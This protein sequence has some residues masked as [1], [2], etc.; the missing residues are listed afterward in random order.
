METLLFNYLL[1]LTE[2]IVENTTIKLNL[3]LRYYQYNDTYLIKLHIPLPENYPETGLSSNYMV[4]Q[5]GIFESEISVIGS[6]SSWI[7]DFNKLQRILQ[8]PARYGIVLHGF[9]IIPKRD[10]I[11]LTIDEQTFLKG[12]GKQALCAG[13]DHIIMILKMEPTQTILLLEASGGKIISEA[14]E[15]SVRDYMQWEYDDL[16]DTYKKQY[17]DDYIS[18]RPS[19]LDKDFMA[20]TLVTTNNNKRLIA[21]YKSTFGFVS[22]DRVIDGKHMGVFVDTFLDHC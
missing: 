13:I 21:Y 5:V 22:L 6:A 17:Y 18:Y 14:D 8:R 9:Y 16:L 1:P 3:V 4:N 11:S 15:E 2:A 12:L 19:D 20:E 10:Q 7:P